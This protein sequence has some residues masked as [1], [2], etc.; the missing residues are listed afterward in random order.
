MSVTLRSRNFVLRPFRKGDETS[1]RRN[2]NNRKIYRYMRLIPHPYTAKHA[3]DWIKK[4]IS[5]QRKKNAPEINFA[6]DIGGEVVGGIG[7]SHIEKYKAEIGYWL[8]EKY[9]GK[10][11][12][13]TTVKLVISFC[14]GKLKLRRIYASI[15]KGNKVSARVLQKAG[16]KLE[17]INR[18]NVLKDG[19]IVDS[20]LYAKVR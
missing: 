18:K 11:I 13:T 7:L 14:F 16:F 10:G 4:N 17:G 2:I 3:N 8:G 12:M 6:I 15:F 9:W 20:I 1:L 5:L 19:R